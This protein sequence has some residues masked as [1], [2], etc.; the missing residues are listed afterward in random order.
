[1]KTLRRVALVLGLSLLL[2]TAAFAGE[3]QGPGAV[4][5]P[6]PTV[7]TAGMNLILALVTTIL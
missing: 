7:D 2:S 5:P 1:M 6:P 4:N 3:M